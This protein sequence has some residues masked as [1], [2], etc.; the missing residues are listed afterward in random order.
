[1]TTPETRQGHR[2]RKPLRLSRR[3]ARFAAWL[4]GGLSFVSLWFSIGVSPEAP[5]AVSGQERT[6]DGERRQV[7]I[8]RTIRRIIV[9]HEVEVPQQP[10]IRYVTVAAPASA[11][12]AGSTDPPTTETKG[13]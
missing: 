10:A 1:M 7:L 13:S 4:A 5:A 9:T 3:S 8:K 2:G 11:P 6:P 12:S